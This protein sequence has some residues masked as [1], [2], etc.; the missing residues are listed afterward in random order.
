MVFK[1]IFKELAEQ[2]DGLLAAHQAFYRLVFIENDAH[3]EKLVAQIK[4]RR[5]DETDVFARRLMGNRIDDMGRR[6]G[7]TWRGNSYRCPVLSFWP[8]FPVDKNT[9]LVTRS[10][11][12]KCPHRVRS[13]LRRTAWSCRMWRAYNKGL[14][15]EV[16]GKAIADT[17][18]MMGCKI[19]PF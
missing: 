11:C 13:R 1:Q 8:E 18:K 6:I 14:T 15:L 10:F 19:R 5:R 17:E 9:V 3:Y 16:W 12:Q 7:I 2:E 4:E